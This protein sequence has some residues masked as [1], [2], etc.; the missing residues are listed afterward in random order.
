LELLLWAASFTMRAKLYVFR[1][2]LLEIAMLLLLL[3]AFTLSSNYLL[4]AYIWW[5]IHIPVKEIRHAISKRASSSDSLMSLQLWPFVLFKTLCK[6]NLFCL[7]YVFCCICFK[8]D[9]SFYMFAIIIWIRRMVKVGKKSTTTNISIRREY[10]WYRR[11]RTSTKD[12]SMLWAQRDGHHHQ[13]ESQRCC[14][15]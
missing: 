5:T 1:C 8:H 14:G 4:A 2:Y 11:W 6:Y 3:Y 15:V 12:S 7:L 9:L 10:S 13:P